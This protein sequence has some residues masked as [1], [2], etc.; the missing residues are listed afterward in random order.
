MSPLLQILCIVLG[1]LLTAISTMALAELFGLRD[2]IRR[3]F[4]KQED[5]SSARQE[6]DKRVVRL[7][8]NCPVCRVGSKP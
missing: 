3:L 8:A 1:V 7:E 6:L 2:D 5:E 4:Q